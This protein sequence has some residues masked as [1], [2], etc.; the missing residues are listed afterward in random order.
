MMSCEPGWSSASRL[1]LNFNEGSS[2]CSDDRQQDPALLDSLSRD[3]VME[4]LMNT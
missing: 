3:H 2:V 4:T 1:L